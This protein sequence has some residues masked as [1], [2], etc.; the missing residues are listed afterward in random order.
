MKSFLGKQ[1]GFTLIEVVAAAA[2]IGVLATVIVPS[3][4]GANDRVKNTKLSNDLAVIDQA[5]QLYRMDNSK[6][7]EKLSDLTVENKYLSG[8]ANFN[9]AKG[10][11]LTYSRDDTANTYSLSGKDTKNTDVFSPGSTKA[12]P[13]DG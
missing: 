2:L 8:N 3:L 6:Y 1:G 9:D 12:V 11:A 7:P 5:I 13:G 4:S 10:E